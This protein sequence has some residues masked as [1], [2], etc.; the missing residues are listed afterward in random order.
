M[1][2]GAAFAE[3]SFIMP[4]TSTVLL[5]MKVFVELPPPEL[6]AFPV[7]LALPAGTSCHCCWAPAQSWY[8][9]MW[10]PS[11]LEPPGTS[12]AMPLKRLIRR[13]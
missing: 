10:L 1:S 11:A 7:P 8:W 13:T 5:P 4:P 9:A 6:P 3:L 12:T 2:N